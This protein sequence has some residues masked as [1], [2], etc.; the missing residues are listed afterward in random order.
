MVCHA[1]STLGC[2]RSAESPDEGNPGMTV[3]GYDIIGD[4]HGCAAQLEALLLDLAYEKSGSTSEYRHPDRHAIFVGDLIDRGDEQLQVLHIVQSMVDAG[5]AMIVM[6]NHEFNALAYDAEWPPDGR[7]TDGVS[8]VG[9]KA[10]P[11]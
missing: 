5:S 8:V 11:P 1:I 9:R 3:R 7:S 2:Q 6:G 10:N 4:V